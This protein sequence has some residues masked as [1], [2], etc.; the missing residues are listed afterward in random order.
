MNRIPAPFFRAAAMVTLPI[1]LCSHVLTAQQTWAAPANPPG[2][3]AAESDLDR[4]LDELTSKLDSMRQ[5][6]MQSQ[7]EMDE[8]RNELAAASANNLAEKSQGETAA[9]DADNTLRA[10]VAQW[11]EE[12]EA[13]VQAQVKQHDQSKGVESSSKYPVRINGAMLVTSIFNSTNSDNFNLPIVAVPSLPDTPRGSLSETASQTILG[14]DAS[15][16]HFGGAKSYADINVDFWGATSSVS[17]TAAAGAI[18]ASD[19]PCAPGMAPS[20]PWRS[21][22]PSRLTS[23]L[24][25]SP[26]RG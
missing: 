6:L 7:N 14:L 20:Q 18:P 21:A 9:H 13:P 12:T 19:G 17:Y 15:G 8:L 4:H 26:R 22:R 5:Q 24:L 3:S 23:S 11:R 10:S 25:R 1:L 16:P 2:S